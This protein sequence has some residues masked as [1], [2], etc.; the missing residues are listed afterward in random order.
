M[1]KLLEETTKAAHTVDLLCG[2]LRQAYSVA[3]QKNALAE[4]LCLEILRDAAK[5]KN[6]ISNLSEAVRHES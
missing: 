4:I 1:N 2:D 6:R 3:V 5:L